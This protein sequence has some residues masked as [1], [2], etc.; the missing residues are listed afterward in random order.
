MRD[1][2]LKRKSENVLLR[3]K[4]MT[5]VKDYQLYLMLLPVITYY[6]LFIYK[7][8]YGLQIAFKDY[9]VYRGIANSPWVGFKHFTAFFQGPFF[10]RLIRNTILL[11]IY[12]LIFGMPLQIILALLFNEIKN[13]TFK[14]AVQTISYLPHF[15]SVVIVAGLVT[16]FLAPSNGMINI[17]RSKLGLE[18]VYFLVVPE[19][20]RTIFTTMNIWK[21]VGFGSIIYMAALTSIDT[22]LYEAAVIDGAGRLKQTWHVTLP[23]IMPTIIIMLILNLGSLLN[24]GYEAII[25][26]Y[27]P[28]TYE[29]ADV[30]STYVYRAGLMENKFALSTAVGFFNSFAALILTTIANYISKKT[31]EISLW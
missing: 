28:V 2:G 10:W 5:W 16:S 20:F 8:M 25:L 23:G 14:K 21:E 12:G 19:Y 15:I 3:R 22:Q 31:S 29:T 13:K 9:N 26:L 4:R 7:P 18:K 27:Q 17:L 6:I 30:L 24:V 11:S 1:F